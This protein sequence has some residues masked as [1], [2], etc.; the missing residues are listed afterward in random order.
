MQVLRACNLERD[1]ELLEFGDQT[2]IGE[3]V[4]TS[5]ATATSP[6]TSA[7]Y[8]TAYNTACVSCNVCH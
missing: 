3:Q 5:N 6:Y 2:E 1:L 7:A 4:R 8:F